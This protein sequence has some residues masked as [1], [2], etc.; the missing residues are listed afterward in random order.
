MSAESWGG[1]TGSTG[2]TGMTGVRADPEP[3]GQGVGAHHRRD[4]RAFLT[5]SDA[6]ITCARGGRVRGATAG[7]LR[8]LTSFL[9]RLLSGLTMS[10]ME[11][12]I[13]PQA[14]I[15]YFIAVLETR[16]GT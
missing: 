1:S 13:T 3:T 9:M 10:C 16:V 8:V 5:H 11:K 15:I 7:G 4:P 14:F 12:S 2:S 6:T